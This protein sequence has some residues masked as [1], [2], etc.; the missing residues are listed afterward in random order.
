M[1]ACV[2]SSNTGCVTSFPAP[3]VPL[4]R[5]DNAGSEVGAAWIASRTSWNVKGPKRGGG[6]TRRSVDAGLVDDGA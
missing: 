3:G 2:V 5:A 6:G 1:R 4:G